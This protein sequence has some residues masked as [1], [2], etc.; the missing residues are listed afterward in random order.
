MFT[1]V[2]LLAFFFSFLSV[3]GVPA[4]TVGFRKNTATQGMIEIY[5][6]PGFQGTPVVFSN[7]GVFN[8]PASLTSNA[9]MRVMTGYRVRFYAN[10]GMVMVKPE[11]DTTFGDDPWIPNIHS[12]KIEPASHARIRPRVL[13]CLTG[14]HPL[15][16]AAQDSQWAYVREHADGIWFNAAGLTWSNIYAIVNK[17]NNRAII[18]EMNSHVKD[19]GAWPSL[20]LTHPNRLLEMYPNLQMT[21]E[22]NSLYKG[23]RNMD[24]LLT[25]N[26]G[27][28]AWAQ[29]TYSHATPNGNAMTYPKI[30]T[31]WQAFPFMENPEGGRLLMTDDGH[32]AEN[33]FIEGDGAFMELGPAHM[34]QLPKYRFALT[35]CASLCHAGGKPFL[36]FMARYRQNAPPA[37]DPVFM[38]SV[39]NAYYIMEADELIQSNDAYFI[40]NYDGEMNV[41]PETHNGQPAATM[42][43]IMYWLLHQGVNSLVSVDFAGTAGSLVGHVAATDPQL[44]RFH[45]A[46][47]YHDNSISV[48]VRGGSS[49][50]APWIYTNLVS[51]FN[52]DGDY[53]GW[54]DHNNRMTNKSVSGGTLKYTI[55]GQSDPQWRKTTGLSLFDARKDAVFEVVLRRTSGAARALTEFF[56]NSLKIGSIQMAD[57]NNWQTLSFPY[58]SG[59]VSDPVTLLRFDP[60]SGQNG[61]WEIDSISVSQKSVSCDDL[62]TS[63]VFA[64]PT[65]FD[66]NLGLA[67]S[68]N[69]YEVLEVAVDVS[70]NGPNPLYFSLG[71]EKSGTQY[72]S[73]TITVPGNAKGVYYVNVEGLNLWADDASS[74]WDRAKGLRLVFWESN[75]T[76]ADS[77]CID[78]I[79]IG[80][81]SY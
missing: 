36:W 71:C 32:D 6:S 1:G 12:L 31:G 63:C 4:D 54:F 64:S 81:N 22:A 76:N 41:L 73:P 51:N 44:N 75:G 33:E 5:P 52:I 59:A 58:L 43:G 18:N 42:T 13:L 14:N 8:A 66:F 16:D 70:A 39:K 61:S 68:G 19:L 20:E 67:A 49:S 79:T 10:S 24:A 7:T 9:S 40:V 53:E 74:S 30:Y 35:D 27:E 15:A 29:N 56:V 17:M 26:V 46:V 60:S 28:I 77:L 34:V 48:G 37:D 62:Y 47:T 69:R 38:Q 72:W 21:Y 2:R 78:R 3:Q 45:S 23:Y 57:N 55:S 65:R 80:G 25:F 11:D 50:T